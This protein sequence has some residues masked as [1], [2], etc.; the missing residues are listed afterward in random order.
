[1]I[2]LQK[3]FSDVF[4]PQ[5]GETALVL[6]DTPHGALH[7][8]P[9]W[10]NRRAMAERWHAALRQLATRRGFRLLPLTCFPATG[11]HNAQ[12]P[13]A[14]LEGGRA[15]RLD[16]LAAET[17]LVIA[18]TQFSASAPLIGW[19]QRF[20]RMRAA[21]MPL[22]APEMEETALAADYT[23]VARSCARLR[24][25]LDD[26]QFA[27][28]GFSNG[29]TL[30]I[31]LRYREAHVDDGLLHAGKTPP[32]LINL[33]GGE[34]Y[35]AAYEGERPG[36]ASE[37]RGVLPLVWRGDIVRV[38][39]ARN[40]VVDVLGRGE[41]AND[42]RSFLSLDAARRNV[43]ELGLGCNPLARVWG[44]ELEDEKAGPHIALGRSEHIGG[45]TGPDEFDNPRHVWHQDF[46][47]AKGSPIHVA[48]MT[49]TG[50]RGETDLL[51][52]NGRY[53]EALEVGI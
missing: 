3:F 50:A 43:A 48:E 41:A 31:D 45:V 25:C 19:T 17:T 40:R 11:A 15:V 49:L 39:I 4:D 20:P 26:A 44:N 29:D 30:T 32:R 22:V 36:E 33:P 53:V 18:M 46:I 27:R 42:L 23:Q 24:G 34:A 38:E 1:M 13:D 5:P 47:Y 21:S 16:E 9:A 8:T 28:I 52:L 7:D 12:L 2:D 6:I 14:G 10:S 37:T 51:V 35:K